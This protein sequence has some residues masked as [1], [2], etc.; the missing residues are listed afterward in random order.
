M[1]EDVD[2]LVLSLG[3]ESDAAL[4]EEMSNMSLASI[5]IGDCVTPRTAEEAVYEG[6]LAGRRI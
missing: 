4:E 6:L 3:H 2:S 1:I 5:S